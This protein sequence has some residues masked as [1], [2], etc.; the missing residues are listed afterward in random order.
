MRHPTEISE[1]DKAST[2]KVSCANSQYERLNGEDRKEQQ[3]KGARGPGLQ[4][5]VGCWSDTERVSAL[6]SLP[7][8]GVQIRFSVWS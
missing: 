7:G 3:H 1:L 6:P 4:L 5:L 8:V 2:G